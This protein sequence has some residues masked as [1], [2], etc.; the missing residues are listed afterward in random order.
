MST[1]K[2][3]Q[4][5]SPGTDG[6]PSSPLAPGN[7]PQNSHTQCGTHMRTLTPALPF[8]EQDRKP[9]APP[10]QETTPRASLHTSAGCGWFRLCPLVS[11]GRLWQMSPIGKI[12]FSQETSLLSNLSPI[13]HLH[14]STPISTCN[15]TQ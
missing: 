8:S 10:T 14:L 2:E 6:H 11:W 1:V 3:S 4:T 9:S 12:N 5:G 15:K 7:T 13:S